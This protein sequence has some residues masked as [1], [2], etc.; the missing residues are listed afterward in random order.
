MRRYHITKKR[1]AGA[2]RYWEC[3]C[4]KKSLPSLYYLSN[5]R[6]AHA[7]CAGMNTQE[8]NPPLTEEEEDQLMDWWNDPT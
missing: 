7:H 3:L 4:G 6:E 1:Q 5:D 2:A 8:G